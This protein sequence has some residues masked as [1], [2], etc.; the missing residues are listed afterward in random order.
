MVVLVFIRSRVEGYYNAFP[1]QEVDELSIMSRHR[2]AWEWR[3]SKAMDCLKTR[4]LSWRKEKKNLNISLVT[5]ISASVT[6]S[7]VPYAKAYCAKLCQACSANLSGLVG[8]P[9]AAIS[10]CR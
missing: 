8:S 6:V 7:R 5:E 1:G 3:C 4:I 9:K 10:N 2:T